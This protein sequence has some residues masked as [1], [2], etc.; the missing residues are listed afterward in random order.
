MSQPCL[1][2]CIRHMHSMF[3]TMESEYWLP[4]CTLATT[5]PNTCISCFTTSLSVSALIRI[6]DNTARSQ[7]RGNYPQLVSLCTCLKTCQA[8]NWTPDKFL[9]NTI[10]NSF[11]IFLTFQPSI[12]GL[13]Q[14]ILSFKHMSCIHLTLFRTLSG[15]C[16][17]W[18]RSDRGTGV[19]SRWSVWGISLLGLK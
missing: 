1:C 18:Q 7:G 4:Q 8:W 16:W 13:P 14:H 17:G 6:C 11:V 15:F 3:D 19:K 10:K 12:F 5:Q 2:G 9:N